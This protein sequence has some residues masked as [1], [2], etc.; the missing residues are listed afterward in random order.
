MKVKKVLSS[1]LGAM[2]FLLSCM[3]LNVQAQ[4]KD[5]RY[6]ADPFSTTTV[7]IT[8]SDDEST[9]GTGIVVGPN[10][11]LT[12]A[13]VLKQKNKIIYQGEH[14]DEPKKTFTIASVKRHP[15]YSP[16]GDT[17]FSHDLAVI[18]TN[19]TFDTYA[20]FAHAEYSLLLHDMTW[21]GYPADLITQKG[22]ISQWRT[23][24][25]AT[26]DDGDISKFVLNEFVVSFGGQS[27]SGVIDNSHPIGPMIIGVLTGG[28][29]PIDTDITLL[30]GSNYDFVYNEVVPFLPNNNKL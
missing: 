14:K 13:H 3:N 20:M 15:D 19:E 28:T 21:I 4:V 26:G 9:W 30:R 24:H 2:F 25:T 12:A 5:T 8:S 1:I 17:K 7:R 29:G 11:V 10:Q 27:G 23:D 6:Q 22:E 16:F 18:T